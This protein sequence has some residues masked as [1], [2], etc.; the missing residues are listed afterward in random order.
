MERWSD[1][2]S[3]GELRTYLHLEQKDEKE[4]RIIKREKERKRIIVK[5]FVHRKP[6][7][8]MYAL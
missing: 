7:H 3:S 6:G 8:P 5:Q 4:G 2:P 1:T